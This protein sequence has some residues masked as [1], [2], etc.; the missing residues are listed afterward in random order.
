MIP[1]GTHEVQFTLKPGPRMWLQ[2]EERQQT[3]LWVK[4]RAVVDAW[5]V[6][7]PVS[8]SAYEQVNH[9]NT[10]AWAS[11]ATGM[12]DGRE[13]RVHVI[14]TPQ[15]DGTFRVACFESRGLDNVRESR[16]ILTPIGSRLAP[17]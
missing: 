7:L 10:L 4:M 6:Q 9:D 3:V 16:L 5:P 14:L 11:T 2:I 17:K 1:A 12:M 8:F 15:S 13:V